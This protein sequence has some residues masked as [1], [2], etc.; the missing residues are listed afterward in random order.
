V[1]VGPAAK[2]FGTGA[3]SRFL[4]L[5]IC[6]PGVD[7]ITMLEP[8]KSTIEVSRKRISRARRVGHK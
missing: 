1:I 6:A 5:C 7:M 8:E 3:A 4:A 2:G